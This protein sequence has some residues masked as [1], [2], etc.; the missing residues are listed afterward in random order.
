MLKALGFLSAVLALP[1][2]CRAAS[3]AAGVEFFES[4]IRPLLVEHCYECHSA[5]ADR[6]EGG[7]RLDHRDGAIRGGDSGPSL[8]PGEPEASLL[9]EAVRYESLEM[10]PAG[11]LAD[12]QIRLLERWTA[13]GAP[14]PESDA[15]IPDPT[16][17]FDLAAR[18]ARHWSWQPIVDPAVPETSGAATPVDS[19]LLEELRQQG[20]SPAETVDRATLARRLSFDLIG[21]P[22]SPHAVERF[23]ND[24]RPDALTRFVDLL[25]ADPAFG[26]RWGRHWLD[27][28]RYAES[29]GH[30]FD[31]DIPGS[32]HYRDYVVRAFNADVPYD[33]YVTEHVAGDL[34]DPPRVDP[35]TGGNE[36]VLGTGFWHLGEWVHSPVDV[37]QDEADRFDNA[38]DVFSKT[39]LATT[40]AC[41]R[42]HDHKFDPVST[43]D[44]YA[45]CGFLQSSDYRLVR[46]DAD[47]QNRRIAQQL[48]E[49]DRRGQQQLR[50]TIA[51]V[52]RPYLQT[53][54]QN[55]L[56]AERQRRKQAGGSSSVSEGEVAADPRVLELLRAAAEHDGDVLWPTTQTQQATGFEELPSARSLLD[57]QTL[58]AAQYYQNGYAFGSAPTRAGELIWGANTDEPIA[59]VATAAQTRRDPLWTGLQNESPPKINRKNAIDETGRAGKVYRSPTFTLHSGKLSYQLRGAGT[60]FVCVGS[61][62]LIFGPLHGNLIKGFDVPNEGPAQWV[63]QQLERYRGQRVHVEI[64][65][66]DDSPL[67]LFQIVDGD[68]LHDAR[69]AT[70]PCDSVASAVDG[71]I[72][73]VDRALTWWSRAPDADVDS[74]QAAFF[75]QHVDWM[76]RNRQVLANPVQLEKIEVE[77]ARVVQLREVLAEQIVRTSRVAPA[78]QEGS[79][80]NQ[81]L[82]IRGSSDRPADAVPRRP[83]TAFGDTAFSPPV[84]GSGRL[85]LARVLTAEE[86]PLVDR[87]IVNRL[88]HHLLG[89]GLVATTDDF[90]V[91]GARPTAPRVL[92]FLASR[93]RRQGRS[94]KTAIRQIVHSDAYARSAIPDRDSVVAD[95]RNEF[96]HY[97]P[98][99]RLDGEAIRDALLHLA[100][101]LDQSHGGA[102]VPVHL[103]AFMDGRG[104]PSR[105]GPKDGRGRRSIYLEVRRNFLSPLLLAFDTPNPFST[106]GRRNE[107]NV[108]AQ[109][110]ILQNNPL[111]HEQASAWAQRVLEREATTDQRI[112]MLYRE[113]FAR[114]PTDEELHAARSFVEQTPTGGWAALAHVLVNVK[115]FIFL[116]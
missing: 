65:A 34:L 62:R 113:A 6:L 43:R 72:G 37:A 51:G 70:R 111:V 26:V 101:N 13:E 68:P 108:P 38:I 2:C 41:A 116:Y 31:H 19:F 106:M 20:L 21:L 99:R 32:Y 89:Q 102:S 79:G 42:C 63:E 8:E 74:A 78:L 90:G 47:A 73:N 67:E 85:E 91:L 94:L 24:A 33:Q 98:I 1:L 36:S 93:F 59:G 22:P 15:T 77:A 11:K 76:W 110:L 35:A 80:E 3:D 18:R 69:L 30:E 109:A 87:V 44:Y 39:F 92:D 115:E 7:L 75:A 105:N 28:V 29:R 50:S 58:P 56:A 12:E 64:A 83:P 9:I 97:R 46:F 23:V 103:T 45:L 114:P 40:V 10:P 48:A 17:A 71:F 84:H 61:H 112:E 57:F 107:S 54:R 52:F 95:P 66:A 4:K 49:V 86:N 88:W 96:W 100:G 60:I 55:L 25:L 14:W 16:E 81:P 104:R 82:L 27:L 5:E 53:L